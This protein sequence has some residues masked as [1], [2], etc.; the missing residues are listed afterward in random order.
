MRVCHGDFFRFPTLPGTLLF[1]AYYRVRTAAAACII[2]VLCPSPFLPSPFPALPPS[3]L[4]SFPLSLPPLS[5]SL[6][7]LSLSLLA[8]L[9][10][11]SPLSL[12]P[13]LPSSLSPSHPLL[14]QFLES[15]RE[16]LLQWREAAIAKERELCLQQQARTQR[17][18]DYV[19]Q[20]L[21]MIEVQLFCGQSH[22]PRCETGQHR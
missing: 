12:S 17:L 18:R 22:F 15:Q 8:S 20:R 21:K 2:C 6:P 9:P 7:P 16:A 1:M 5:P 11:S 3:P 13:S 10:P 19:Q 4:P 14:S